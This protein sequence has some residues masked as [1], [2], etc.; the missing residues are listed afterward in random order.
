VRREH[1]WTFNRPD[2][3]TLPNA[4]TRKTLIASHRWLGVGL[5]SVLLLWFSSG[6]GMMYWEFP[7]V[8]A[9]DRLARSPAIDAS[10]IRL[11]PL[12]AFRRAGL[13]EQALGARLTM[14]DGR[15]AYRFQTSAEQAI[16]YADT[17]ERQLAVSRTMMAR[18]AS[19]WTG[20][21]S[22][23]ASITEIDVDQWTVEGSF[24]TLGP[25]WKFSWPNGEAVYV[26]QRTGEVVQYTTSASRL[27]AYLGPIP[28]WLYF[29]PLRRHATV[30]SAFIIGLSGAATLAALLGLLLAAVVYSPRRRYRRAGA[31]AANPYSGLKRWHLG[32]GLIFGA[33]AATWAFSGMLSMYPFARSGD[34]A[35]SPELLR[36]PL[37]LSA[38]AAKPPQIVLAQLAG[39]AV[40]ELECTSLGTESMY[41]ASVSGG[42]RIVPVAGS[43]RAEFDERAIRAALA[44]SQPAK[45][46]ELKR[47]TRYDRYYLDRHG[48]LPLPVLVARVDDAHSTRYYIDPRTARII[49]SYRSSDWTERWLYH[50]LHSLDFPWLYASRPSWD[51]LVL[52]FMLGG[53]ALGVSALV[54][55]WRVVKRTVRLATVNE[56]TSGEV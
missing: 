41:I 15:P 17:G 29:T 50:G 38:F 39:L 27:G 44:G 13:W 26:S 42:F 28:H 1:R 36:A 33:S 4:V 2:R 51:I 23:T 49:S 11:S 7:A 31:P 25:L 56:E 34:L 32:L 46:I 16:V 24:R 47:S 6:I 20:Q 8:P 18:A 10:A 45:L 54:L 37:D 5:C 53:T 35:S 43:P 19:G 40:K 30:W 55:A 22:S 52:A 9:E 21:P 12:E 3:A 14:L 48:R